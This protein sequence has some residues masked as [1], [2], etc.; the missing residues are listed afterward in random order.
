[1]LL[2]LPAWHSTQQAMLPP[3]LLLQ[4]LL[5]CLVAQR[6]LLLPPLHPTPELTLPCL[7]SPPAMLLLL[8]QV[9]LPWLL[10]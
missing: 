8:L 9:V 10:A 3:W 5:P 4:L 7:K 2:L 6:A 1:V